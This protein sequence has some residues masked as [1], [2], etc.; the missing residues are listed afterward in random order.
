MDVLVDG[1]PRTLSLKELIHHYVVHQREVVTCRT[2]FEL[3]RAE[4]RAAHPRGAAGRARQPRR[5]DQADPRLRRPDA[6]RQRADRQVQV[7]E[8]QAQAILDMRLQRLTALESDKVRTEHA[9][10]MKRVAELRAILGD[11]ARIDGLIVEELGEIENRYGDERRT[12]I[13]VARAR[14]TSRT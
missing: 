9:G 5:G 7:T 13:T 2:Q 8:E 14:S 11:E 1:V 3:R 4:A 10:L 6:A 12:E